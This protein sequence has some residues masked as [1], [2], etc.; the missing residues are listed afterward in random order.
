MP[1]RA[2]SSAWQIEPGG[3]GFELLYAGEPEV[4]KWSDMKNLTASVL[5][6]GLLFAG[7]TTA[8]PPSEKPR[9][10]LRLATT[11]STQ[12]SGLLD[13]LIPV[14]QRR[15]KCRVDV[16][17]VGTGAAL[18]LG[19]AGDVDVLLVHARDDEVAFMEAGH[20]IRREE[21]MFN[22]FEIVGPPDDPAGVRG[23]EPVAGLQ[24]IAS[25]E[26]RFVS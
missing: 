8:Q 26:C 25:A 9:A 4:A 22:F 2:C 6:V 10:V 15:Q 20:G 14:F 19:Q 18:K 23:T 7:C 1:N 12:D 13:V 3:W 21:V 11:T 16:I 17:A 5:L 24:K